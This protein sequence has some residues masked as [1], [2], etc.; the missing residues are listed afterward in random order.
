MPQGQ[1]PK[2]PRPSQ[3][4]VDYAKERVDTEA[5]RL[6][7]PRE[8]ARDVFR[9]ESGHSPAVISGKRRS[10][11]GA[12]GAMQLMP[13]TAKELKVDPEDLD[14]NITGGLT[15]LKRQLDDFGGDWTKAKA[16]YN[17]GPG[18][19][20]KYGGVPP[21]AETRAYAQP[22]SPTEF[23]KE[24]EAASATTEPRDGLMRFWEQPPSVPSPKPSAQPYS[25]SP[26]V[27]LTPARKPKPVSPPQT[28]APDLMRWY[29][30]QPSA[31]P[32]TAK[33]SPIT[34][35][36]SS[37][38]IPR[39]VSEPTNQFLRAAG[40]GL[41]R[42]PT[43]VAELADLIDRRIGTPVLSAIGLGGQGDELR[44]AEK[45]RPVMRPVEQAIEAATPIDPSNQSW[46]TA[47]IPRAAGSLVPFVA[48]GLA[49]GGAK[50]A[51][52]LGAAMNAGEIAREMENAGVDP[53]KRDRA[54]AMA[55]A[56]GLTE[57]LGIG[58]M[59]N[60]FGLKQAF[61]HRAVNIMEEAGQEGLQEYLNNINAAMVGGYD[62]SR[63]ASRGVIEAAVLGGILGGGMQGLSAAR[64]GAQRQQ[65]IQA[66]R[67]EP[68]TPLT[69]LPIR[70]V[71]PERAGVE[72]RIT[73]LPQTTRT[74]E[75]RQQA[76]AA[77][78]PDVI[79]T[80][81]EFLAQQE[82]AQPPAQAGTTGRLTQ[83]AE[84]LAALG[85]KPQAETAEPAAQPGIRVYEP[86]ETPETPAKGRALTTVTVDGVKHFVE[87]PSNVSRSAAIELAK[88]QITAQP[89]VTAPLEAPERAQPARGTIQAE[90]EP[91]TGVVA[92]QTGEAAPTTTGA[93]RAAAD[94]AKI[95]AAEHERAGR[96]AEAARAYELAHRHLK[97]LRRTMGRPQ[98]PEAVAAQDAIDREIGTAAGNRGQAMTNA[99]RA[100]AQQRETQR[101]QQRMEAAPTREL[102]VPQPQTPPSAPLLGSVMNPAGGVP[103]APESPSGKFGELVRQQE[104][105]QQA[106]PQPRRKPTGQLSP[107]EYLKRKTGGK[108]IRVSDAGERAMLGAKEAGIVGLVRREGGVPL[109]D[110][111]VMLDE[112]GFT[113]PDGRPFTDR[114][115]T[116]N[117]VLD[118]LRE[119]GKEGRVDTRG[120][121]RRLTEEE[122]EYYGNL[123]PEAGP[124]QPLPSSME[125]VTAGP[126][127]PAQGI[128]EPSEISEG[129]TGA[130]REV[131]DFFDQAKQAETAAETQSAVERRAQTLVERQGQQI[132]RRTQEREAAHKGVFGKFAERAH[133]MN[134]GRT[135]PALA[136][137]PE[138]RELLDLPPMP[139]YYLSEEGGAVNPEW[140][141]AAQD[142]LNALA[143]KGDKPRSSE[144][145]LDDLRGAYRRLQIAAR[146][147]GGE[148]SDSLKQTFRETV[149]DFLESQNSYQNFI[150][151]GRIDNLLRTL[152]NATQPQS[153]RE[154]ARLKD[155][156]AAIAKDHGLS[157]HF[158]D[159]WFTQAVDEARGRAGRRGAEA[160]A[161]DNQGRD[162]RI[163]ERDVS[164]SA[165]E[166]R[167][168]GT[169][170]KPEPT[171]PEG[172]KIQ[173]TQFGAVTEAPDQSGVA[174]GHLRVLDGEGEPHVIQNPR[175][176][177]NQNA[178]FV[179][180]R[181]TERKVA[182]KE[183][184][185]MSR[186]EYISERRRQGSTL[187][188][189]DGQQHEN[190]VA[191]AVGR[192]EN[193]PHR[194][195][196]RYPNIKQHP[197][198]REAYEERTGQP[199]PQAARRQTL[200]PEQKRQLSPYGV[201]KHILAADME[202]NDW[203][204]T[205]NYNKTE[206]LNAFGA[207][208]LRRGVENALRK[209]RPVPAEVLADYPDL[210]P[211]TRA[212]TKAAAETEADVEKQAP[213]PEQERANA[214]LISDEIPAA[215]QSGQPFAHGDKVEWTEG[216][217]TLR[218]TVRGYDRRGKVM[219]YDPSDGATVKV[220]EGGL[221]KRE[222]G[223]EPEAAAGARKPLPERERAP[224][225]YSQLER[226]IEQKMPNK[227]SGAQALAI[228]TNPQN[229]VKKEEL[230]WLGLAEWLRPQAN[231]TKQDVLDFVRANQ[232]TVQEVTHGIRA[233]QWHQD[234]DTWYNE[235]NSIA[236]RRGNNV[237]QTAGIAL[238]GE[239]LETGSLEEAQQVADRA[240]S[241]DTKYSQLT[242]PGTEEGSYRELLLTMPEIRPEQPPERITQLPDGYRVGV[243]SS[244]PPNARWHVLPPEQVHGR[245][246]YGSHPSEEAAV[247]SALQRLNDQQQ[248]EWE[249]SRPSFQSPHWGES[250]VLAHI[251]FNER[252]DA[253]G[254]RTLFIEEI[255]SDWHQAGR[256]WG[257]APGVAARIK[258]IN[259]RLEEI[260]DRFDKIPPIEEREKLATE[261]RELVS[262]QA[263][264][265]AGQARG[266]VPDAPFKTSW[267]ELA[268][269][270]MLRYGAENG[271]DKIAW[272]TGETQ[273]ER[274]DLSKQ[275]DEVLWTPASKTIRAIKDG[276]VLISKHLQDESGLPD[277]V[278]KE[279][280][281]RLL[282]QQPDQFATRQ[283][284]EGQDTLALGGVDLKVGGEG[285]R[286]FYDQIL[287]SFVNRY[288]KKW[289]IKVEQGSVPTERIESA[290]GEWVVIKENQIVNRF[291]ADEAA[292]K[293]YARQ[294]DGTEMR[295]PEQRYAA[296]HSVTITPAMRDSVMQ[297]QPLFQREPR[298]SD[299]QPAPLSDAQSATDIATNTRTRSSKSESRANVIY[300]NE[301][302]H[303]WIDRA[304]HLLQLRKAKERGETYQHTPIYG[305]NL[306]AD[307]AYEFADAI[308]TEKNSWRNKPEAERA[309]ADAQIEAL[310]RALEE[311]ADQYGRVLYIAGTRGFSETRRTVYHEL[312]HNAERQYKTTQGWFDAQPQA[313]K[314]SQA[315]A[316]SGYHPDQYTSETIAHVLGGQYD[317]LG[318]T[319]D[320]A[321]SWLNEYME[322]ISFR[323][324]RRAPESFEPLHATPE[325]R[326]ALRQAKEKHG[327][328]PEYRPGGE[329]IQGI[330][331]RNA[332]AGTGGA[333]AGRP[334]R[335]RG[336]GEEGTKEGRETG[337]AET[338]RTAGADKAGT[339]PIFSLG[340]LPGEAP[341]GQVLG[342][343]GGV[344]Q[345]RKTRPKAPL[346]KVPLP[347]GWDIAQWAQGMSAKLA[348]TTFTPKQ[349]QKLNDLINEVI[350]ATNTNDGAR[351]FA[352][353]EEMA[354]SFGEK[355]KAGDIAAAPRTFLGG[356]DLSF[357]FRQGGFYNLPGLVFRPVKTARL[358]RSGLSAMKSGNFARL[359][360]EIGADPRAVEMRKA[361]LH[362]INQ[363]KVEHGNRLSDREDGYISRAMQNIPLYKQ[364]ERG[365]TTLLDMLRAAKY[366]EHADYMARRGATFDSNPEAYKQM[367]DWVNISTGRGSFGDYEGA[368]PFLANFLWSP[369]W[370]MS[371]IQ[372][373]NPARYVKADPAFRGKM[374]GDLAQHV[375][376]LGAALGAAAAA[377]A[378]GFPI[379]V[380][381]DPDDADF[382]KVVINGRY[383]Y[384]L[385]GGMQQYAV[386][387]TRMFQAAKARATAKTERDRRAAIG[388]M[389]N[390]M[391]RFA[392]GKSSPVAGLAADW[393]TGENYR[394][395]P[396]TMTDALLERA[397][398]IMARDLY[399]AYRTAGGG[400]L[401]A[402]W[403]IPAFGGFGVSSYQ[404]GAKPKRTTQSPVGLEKPKRTAPSAKRAPVGLEGK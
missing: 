281:E 390:T 87:H 354:R 396:V 43:G 41:A 110:V 159:K 376:V 307:E 6:G 393:L 141:T 333:V 248:E 334:L 132:A 42:I 298:T 29:E 346:P 279:V 40:T 37:P 58:R 363:V 138:L 164:V 364:T 257:Y 104:A 174:K 190:M 10:S 123:P 70:P 130:L 227:A 302:A 255:Q 263:K 63:P 339:R 60:K 308:R 321:T 148:I 193:V 118:Y 259:Q 64:A 276:Q 238:R 322:N 188:R 217:T 251:R 197:Q 384:D 386:F 202:V 128:T 292:A 369:R 8:L 80:P 353:R 270:R 200:S 265:E 146:Q 290:A 31:P 51:A 89:P 282:R 222:Q 147:R 387:A 135:L 380:G 325:M 100:A 246:F 312:S 211:K 262:E 61:I 187:A 142:T 177:G 229:G 245:P 127:T 121:E 319:L 356:L 192:G 296:V 264:L 154:Q 48:G 38:W 199:V 328:R 218:G 233:H 316:R 313:D 314:L 15:Y 228:A 35:S 253:G 231:V 352:A 295:E 52:M 291:G 335:S 49:G 82:A 320:E 26:A 194:V 225:F 113:L 215:P 207:Q 309:A 277:V 186:D 105:A 184:W 33:P 161:G 143:E 209:G 287:P 272:A 20:R 306:S 269:K 172:R 315:L 131:G 21:Y 109:S 260:Q 343:F 240:T 155:S 216:K 129:T 404:A 195:L 108:G 223:D 392:R 400:A 304:E 329:T 274:S 180:E 402:A 23:L 358:L 368:V 117:D 357:A 242:L 331:Q 379:T 367:A 244:Q 9:R 278:G 239:P 234:G 293:Q 139:S 77:G 151:D 169:F 236:I 59:L 112:G 56:T 398:P 81:T 372:M 232:V 55:G 350:D 2:R 116:E 230:D 47:K 79:P 144:L 62:P 183:P 133:K 373:L 310:A 385:T 50:T 36:E 191:A 153:K 57:A 126:Q 297:G 88:Q 160:Q 403:A 53:A 360:A 12:I 378:A 115:V 24:M 318:L 338:P 365:N 167:G 101:V 94:D 150:V 247:A 46:V 267:P 300:G 366:N 98:S 348:N 96:F 44:L 18:A 25:A 66:V 178:A 249:K 14:Q 252:T 181:E 140:T 288:V 289:G 27:P 383:H 345:G 401:G 168:T 75:F 370:V 268:F 122:A 76:E 208:A 280:A 111:Q 74:A 134:T 3:F 381:S 102:T 344:F 4:L 286:G 85:R 22:Q 271:Y 391:K 362:L 355:F 301:Q 68:Q 196:S 114:S 69:R 214:I 284:G 210:Q 221:R 165:Q 389:I 327:R 323:T 45:V 374:L 254:K 30:Q 351:L 91:L 95:E 173:H 206:L 72:T 189:L 332:A 203:W 137:H 349:N 136:E 250:N 99:R 103:A 5:D 326:A 235:D 163:D 92:P 224:G 347:T 275:V 171:Q 162:R 166:E 182:A 179:K 303:F 342:A 97:S 124:S 93:L 226:V 19:V 1:Q 198:Y 213:T 84:R 266:S 243:D 317:K 256:K 28:A 32:I 283:Y 340:A 152:D 170:G 16:A 201:F 382:G 371:R 176:A 336:A 73:N 7:V 156:V 86:G 377:G 220:D 149:A 175:T 219:V 145:D 394:G 157:Q 375:L 273:A 67:A 120:L 17:A 388:H 324:E 299:F 399:D 305:A 361:G 65:D 106:Q 107:I 39:S 294:V 119:S 241:G 237:W 285:M 34:A 311:T 83:A 158:A 54:I 261:Q 90:T 258:S 185:E 212:E 359:N 395:K 341:G 337:A 78:A 397:T 204:S 71:A 11:A 205:P 13:G 330:V 125:N